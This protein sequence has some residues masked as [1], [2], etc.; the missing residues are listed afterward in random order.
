M[1]KIKCLILAV[2]Y[3]KNHEFNYY[4]EELENLTTAAGFEPIGRFTQKLEQIDAKSYFK[5]GK[6][7]EVAE[8]CENNSVDL[9]V[10]NNE[11]SGMQNRNIEEITGV[12]VMDRTQL[13]LEIFA[14]RAESKEA[15]LQ[16]SIAQLK[17]N[18]PRMI[19]SYDNLSRQGGGKVGTVAR[20]SGEKKL[21]IDKRRVRDQIN[22]LE[23]ELVKYE[24]SRNLQREKRRKS[25]VPI[26]AV[27]GYTN[28]GK[29]TLMNNL[30]GEDKQVFEKDM[31]F[32]TLD[33][34]VRKIKLANKREFL[35]VDTVGFV[36]NLPHDLV[37]AF[38]STLEEILEADLIIHL[39][40]GLSP[41][42]QI[43]D[44]VVN[45]TLEKLG[46]GSIPRV[47]VINKCDVTTIE[48]ENLQISA[49]KSINIDSFIAMIIEQ[50]FSDYQ[51]V[52]MK[53]NYDEMKILDQIRKHH[54]VEAVE[55]LDDG[56]KCTVELSEMERN[57][58]QRNIIK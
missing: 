53:F 40:D 29:S 3:Y 20:G 51:T 34:A 44:E 6:I 48:S 18:L 42:R 12:K 46:A 7:A 54:Q 27:V 4:L 1:K 56:V 47:N 31:L 38:G 16:V 49:K 36:S 39:E 13:I 45:E 58:Y 15:K 23:N 57:I 19:G 43:H 9:I 55:Y 30:V 41:Y 26:V 22:F 32:A 11:I 35:L 5:K 21:E 8:Y 28:A 52:E 2:D 14:I 25:E 37:K 33:T 10:V 24:K 17:Y 50:I